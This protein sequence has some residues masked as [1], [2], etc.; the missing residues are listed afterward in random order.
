MTPISLTGARD[1]GHDARRRQRDPPLGNA[2]PFA[3]GGHIE[4]VAH[5]FEI[6]QRFSISIITTLEMRRFSGSPVAGAARCQSQPIARQHDLAGDLA[7]GE[8]AHQPL[9]TVWQN[10]QLSVQPTWLEMHSV[11][12]SGSGM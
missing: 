9:R 7:G 5:R 1:V 8:I 10:K 11:P 12:R 6:V 2:Q 3:V 4:A